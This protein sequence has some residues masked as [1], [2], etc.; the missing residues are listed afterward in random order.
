MLLFERYYQR[1]KSSVQILMKVTDAIFFCQYRMIYCDCVKFFATGLLSLQ[2]KSLVPMR[3]D[4]M[5]HLQRLNSGS[6]WNFGHKL[7]YE[8]GDN[9]C[10]PRSPC[11]QWTFSS[12]EN[13]K[14]NCTS[15]TQS[16]LRNWNRTY[17]MKFKIVH[18]PLLGLSWEI[19]DPGYRSVEINTLSIA[20]LWSLFPK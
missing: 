4:N 11:S 18:R 12:A 14:S 2:P 6:S 10:P 20:P 19:V 7:I 8:R 3:G 1:E 13:I 9:N 5:S 15:P 16:I 17:I